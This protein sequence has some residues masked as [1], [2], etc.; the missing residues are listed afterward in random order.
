M[1][2][3]PLQPSEVNRACQLVPLPCWGEELRQAIQALRL[4]LP[5]VLMIAPV[6]NSNILA[7]S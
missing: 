4:H 5:A 2:L 3:E 7:G 6:S 1:R